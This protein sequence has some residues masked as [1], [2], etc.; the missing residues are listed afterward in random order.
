MSVAAS[1]GY[2]SSSLLSIPG[3]A[4]LL[5]GEIVNDPR[6]VFFS[7]GRLFNVLGFYYCLILLLKHERM[8]LLSTFKFP[9]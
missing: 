1:L 8:L 7:L 4:S 9:F 3:S 2:S 5:H 6:W